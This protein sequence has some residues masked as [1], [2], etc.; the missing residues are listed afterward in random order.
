MLSNRIAYIIFLIGLLS[1]LLT[2]CGGSS[3]QPAHDTTTPGD[4]GLNNPTPVNPPSSD[5]NV[6][7]DADGSSSLV[8]VAVVLGVEE[9]GILML[10]LSVLSDESARFA[11]YKKASFGEVVVQQDG[12]F[13]YTPDAHFH[14]TDSF[15]FYAWNEDGGS[16]PATVSIRVSPLGDAPVIVGNP[17]LVVRQGEVYQTQFF[18]ADA[19][20][21]NFAFVSSE[22][23]SWLE[24]DDVTGELFGIPSQ[25]DVGM[26][27]VIVSAVDASGVFSYYPEFSIEVIDV[28]DPPRL[29]FSEFPATL[30]A[31][32]TIIIDLS[33]YDLDGDGVEISVKEDSS[34]R[35]QIIGDTIKL[36]ATDVK[37]VTNIELELTASDDR[38]AKTV[39]QASL[40]LY[41]LN[42]S[43]AGRT[44]L[45][46]KEGSGIHIV[47]VGDGYQENE[48]TLF[49]GHVE[50]LIDMMLDDPAIATHVTA[51]NIHAV[52][53][54]SADTGID[55]QFGD[56][57][58]NT[59]FDSGYYCN[60]I[61]RLICAD[62]LKM[63]D[64]ALAEYEYLDQLIL[65][66]ND[67]RFGGSGGSVAIAS[68]YFPEIAIH[69]MGHSIARLADEYVDG[70]IDV[71]SGFSLIEGQYP[72]V[73]NLIDPTAVPW[74]H[75][76]TDVNN[77]PTQTGE[78]GVGI[79]EGAF[80]REK[81]LYRPTNNSRMRSNIEPFGPINGEQW[82]FSLYRKIGAV[83]KF[84][85]ALR[86]LTLDSGK[87]T[88]FFVE[89][90][91]D[92]TLQR[93]EWY[94]NDE[95][96]T[97]QLGEST[98]E[99]MPPVGEH[100][101]EVRVSDISGLVRSPA[102]NPSIFI[103]QWGLTVQ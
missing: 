62:E 86:R 33:P 57:A 18:A 48:D 17:S 49:A 87:E 26:H 88:T 67:R 38:G 77:Y 80:Y 92:N 35:S 63:F 72:N 20:S 1:V 78:P 4:P 45:G 95:L 91:F 32:Q 11:L 74:S 93:I 36:T 75:W 7:P 9:D 64:R 54:I 58:R 68:A 13:T 30:D 10:K 85:P 52:T 79:F 14:G 5:P 61:E 16:L 82:V 98:W 44:V 97:Q 19:D 50:N 34:V 15:E 76:I 31:R 8:P 25:I 84:G 60:N 73:S 53:S 103:W 70:S 46:S 56:D 42:D 81:E 24:L 27:T 99:F 47:I 102:N 89:T 90:T 83:D 6:P 23:P 101:L 12:Q 55:D 96:V 94:F 69:E 66:A 39:Q 41:P 40:T 100:S 21:E 51:L 59:T 43:G 3:E 71:A 29:D 28:N 65:L 2:G 37:T 22:L